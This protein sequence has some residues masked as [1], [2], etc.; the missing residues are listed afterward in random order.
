MSATWIHRTAIVA[1]GAELGE[2]V[3][4]G[5]FAIIEEGVVLGR[6][7]VVEAHA[8]VRTGTR[9]GAGNVV[10]PF[11]VLGGS[12]QDRRYD[13]EPTLLEIGDRNVFREHATVHRGTVQGGGV[14]RVGSG[15]LFMASVHVGHDA[16]VGDGVILANATLLAGHVTVGDHVVTGG[17]V[18][19][20]PFGKIGARAFLAGGAMVER[21]IPPF[22]I[23]SGD[24]AR[25]RALNKVGL[26]RGGVPAA[27]IT[28]L[29]QAFT[30]IFRKGTPRAIAAAA[31][32]G[33]EDAFVRMLAEAVAAPKR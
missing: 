15:G 1:P 30:A 7:T 33:H 32:R 14:T 19:I 21:D 4:I 28:A 8:L 13:G 10:H 5:A 11:A 23:A 27:S 29:E 18:A 6:G 20:A 24:R 2:G 25:V 22:V 17:H 12:P 9:L 16:Q 31:L 26:Q 3:E